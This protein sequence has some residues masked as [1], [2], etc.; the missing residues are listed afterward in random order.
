MTPLSDLEKH[1]EIHMDKEETLNKVII[2]KQSWR[3][4]IPQFQEIH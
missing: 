2:N 3:Y 4:H 1:S